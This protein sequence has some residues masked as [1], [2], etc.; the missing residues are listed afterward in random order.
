MRYFGLFDHIFEKSTSR[1]TL[2]TWKRLL[3]RDY[4]LAPKVNREQEEV[5]IDILQT[6]VLNRQYT[7]TKGGRILLKAEKHQRRYEGEWLNEFK[8]LSD[9][10]ENVLWEI[11][12]LSDDEIV[13]EFPTIDTMDWEE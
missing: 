9:A 2:N 5:Y 7:I 12:E 10:L 13:E 4:E 3:L 1:N 11:T 8:D 6:T